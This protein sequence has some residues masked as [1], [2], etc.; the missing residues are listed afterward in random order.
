MR[1]S[2]TLFIYVLIIYVTDI[3]FYYETIPK[4]FLLLKVALAFKNWMQYNKHT[5]RIAYRQLLSRIFN[6]IS[7]AQ[8]LICDMFEGAFYSKLFQNDIYFPLLKFPT[9]PSPFVTS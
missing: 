8:K 3:R 9:S 7:H 6:T 2:S 4:R 1:Q 5:S